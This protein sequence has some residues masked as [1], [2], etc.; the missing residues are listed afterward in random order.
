ME[1]SIKPIKKKIKTLRNDL[2]KLE[3][4]ISKNAEYEGLI[5]KEPS[6][7]KIEG[8]VIGLCKH[9]DREVFS[10]QK[11]PDPKEEGLFCNYYCRRVYRNNSIK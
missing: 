11:I 8:T 5:W 1:F 7:Y 3:R 9:C 6:G 10:G 2:E 4:S